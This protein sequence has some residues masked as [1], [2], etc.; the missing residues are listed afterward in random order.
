MDGRQWPQVA[1]KGQYQGRWIEPIGL[2]AHGLYFLPFRNQGP[3]LNLPTRG[4]RTKTVTGKSRGRMPVSLSS[5][6]T[7]KSSFLR[8]GTGVTRTTHR[9][10]KEAIQTTD[11]QSFNTPANHAPVLPSVALLQVYQSPSDGHHATTQPGCSFPLSSTD[12]PQGPTYS[13]VGL[14]VRGGAK[15]RM[16]APR[17][18]S[19]AMGPVYP[20]KSVS[21][22]ANSTSDAT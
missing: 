21:L 16:R 11:I 3:H 15:T 13:S 6:C 8:T 19:P 4:A 12:Q 10:L 22:A 20:P 7:P 1:C 2:S 5:L 14:V 9:T 17:V 18:M